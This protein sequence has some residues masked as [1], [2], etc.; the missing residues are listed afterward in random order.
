MACPNKLFFLRG[1]HVPK[2]SLLEFSIVKD[3]LIF[4]PPVENISL[5]TFE[6]F[7][8]VENESAGSDE[9]LWEVV[10]LS[11]TERMV[12]RLKLRVIAR[13]V[14]RQISYI[15]SETGMKP[16]KPENRCW[17][18]SHVRKPQKII[19]MCVIKNI[20]HVEP[21]MVKVKPVALFVS[22]GVE[23]HQFGDNPSALTTYKS[24]RLS[25]SGFCRPSGFSRLVF[26][27]DQRKDGNC[28]SRERS[29]SQYALEKQ[30]DG[31]DNPFDAINRFFWCDD[32]HVILIM[33]IIPVAFFVGGICGGGLLGF[34]FLCAKTR[35]LLGLL[36]VGCLAFGF[37]LIFV[38][39][40]L[41]GFPALWGHGLLRT[42]RDNPC[43]KEPENSD[44]LHKSNTVPR[45]YHLTSPNYW[46]TVIGIG[47]T[48]MPT[49]L[50]KDKQIAVISALAEGSG[51]RQIERITGVNRNT[52]MNL[53]VRVGQGCARV[54]DQK[55]RNLSC[56][57]LQFDEVWGFIGKKQ[58]NVRPE[59]DQQLGDVWTFCAIDADTKIVPSFKC[60]KRDHI[61]ANAF[62]QDV[63]NRMANR[64]Q[65]SSAPR[66]CRNRLRYIVS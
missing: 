40:L 44:T 21:G 6:P 10:G 13:W 4:H 57:Q 9:A 31:S 55:M 53:G 18:P 48:D 11:A 60:G 25:F 62:V 15:F 41:L 59:D 54:L 45:K 42:T 65:I 30:F 49:V 50:A 36:G 47:R 28:Y 61:T 32:I 39:I 20:I 23:D 35:I 12:K 2:I 66:A 58:K 34:A 29:K 37:V 38:G 33:A 51:I 22:V 64:V 43:G 7:C 63:A 3:V 24:G 8:F 46:G 1:V 5:L 56:Q 26:N 17:S 27:R 16:S 14:S 19:K 52:I